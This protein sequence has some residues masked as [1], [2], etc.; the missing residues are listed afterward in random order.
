MRQLLTMLLGLAAAGCADDGALLLPSTADISLSQTDQMAPGDLAAGAGLDLS[1]SA[2]LAIGDLAVAPNDLL[3]G[4]PGL[5][6]DFAKLDFGAVKAG[7]I[8][9]QALVV[10][11]TGAAEITITTI[12]LAGMNPNIFRL[13]DP[14]RLTLAGCQSKTLAVS[15]TPISRGNYAATV[16]ISPAGFAPLQVRL[17]GTGI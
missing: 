17:I 9:Q 12:T 15:F 10:A 8:G 5:A 7:Q 3:C 13:A 1:S 4:P 2:D 11:N 14:G 16:V 6:T